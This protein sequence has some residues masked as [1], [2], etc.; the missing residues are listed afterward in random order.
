MVNSIMGKV[1]G[2]S[3]RVVLGADKWR[4]MNENKKITGSPPGPGKT[5]KK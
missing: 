4:E 2:S 3:S 1:G 5:F